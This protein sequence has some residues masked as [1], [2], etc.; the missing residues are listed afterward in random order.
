MIPRFRAARSALAIAV[1]AIAL[2]GAPARAQLYL[3]ALGQLPDAIARS[4][5]L[6][7]IGRLELVIP[8]RHNRIN[9]WDYAGNPAGLALDDSASVLYLR[10]STASASSVQ[11]FN[12]AIGAGERQNF[13]GRGGRMGYEAWRRIPGLSVFGA[14]GDIGQQRVDQSYTRDVELRTASAHPNVM[15]LVGGR[16]PYFWSPRLH[17]ALRL[18]SGYQTINDEYRLITRNAAGEYIDRNG[19]LGSPPDLFTPDQTTVETF[20]GGLA[21]AYSFSKTLT[22]AVAGDAVRRKF[23][24]TNDG[25]RYVSERD[26]TRP[27][28]VGQASLVGRVGRSFEWGADGRTWNSSSTETWVFS[29]STNTGGAGAPPFAGRGDYVRREEKGS[30]LRAR[31]RWTSGPLELGGNF[32]TSYQK[33]TLTPPV[34]SDQNSFNS[35]LNT[36]FYRGSADT[37]VYPDSVVFTERED[38][39]WVAGAGASWRFARR[40]GILG[41]EYHKYRIKRDQTLSGF[42]PKAVATDPDPA[43]WTYAEV[44][45]QPSGWDLRVGLEYPLLPTLAGRAGYIHR[46]DD[47]NDLTAQNEQVANTATAG[48]GLAPEGARWRLDA[49]Y[50][51]QWWQADYGTP[52]LPRGSR[53]LI[54]AEIGWVF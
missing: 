36:I 26:E 2:G 18:V 40:G 5:R 6:V 17:Y 34:I 38:R 32:G 41:V 1:A 10:P 42:K 16:V 21:A 50:E 44:G 11:D 14:I 22:A 51:L 52:A 37:T 47:F 23:H 30:T 39:T 12:D 45:P 46:S 8:D 48:L 27:M 3:P 43:S 35:F 24:G 53:Q 25:D 7:G 15:A 33:V 49:S 4:P 54:V 9:L 29:I 28:G 13:A 19:T 20:G 31:A